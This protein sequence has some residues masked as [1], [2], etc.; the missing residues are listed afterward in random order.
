MC[1]NIREPLP[2]HSIHYE[3]KKEVMMQKVSHGKTKMDKMVRRREL[4]CVRGAV[5][6]ERK[7]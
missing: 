1:P 6:M 4:P 3:K 5:P 7:K 2:A